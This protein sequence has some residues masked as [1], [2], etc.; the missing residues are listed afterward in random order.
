VAGCL[1]DGATLVIS[2]LISLQHDQIDGIQQE[3]LGEATALAASVSERQREQRLEEL[4][5]E[6]EF[7]FMAPEQLTREETVERLA[8]SDVS[9]LVVDEAHCISEWG[10]ASAPTTCAS[11]RWS[12]N[13][14]IPPSWP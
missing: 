7:L 13:W 3:P 2:P 12:R 1:V 9:L 14:G 5:E 4:G 8:R 11:G 10:T 6:I